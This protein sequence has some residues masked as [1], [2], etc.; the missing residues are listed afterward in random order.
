MNR[1]AWHAGTLLLV[2][3]AAVSA[4]PAP[5][6]DPVLIGSK[7][8]GKLTQR[9][10]FATGGTG[11]P[12]FKIVLTITDRNR[13]SFEAE[14][15]EVAEAQ[16]LSITY[17]VKGEIARDKDGKGYVIKFKSVAAKDIENTNPLLGIPYEAALTG[18]TMKGTWKI[19]RNKDGIEIEGDFEVELLKK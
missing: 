4:A 19:P 1:V 14:L 18:R 15:R 17:L 12:E 16:S 6:R 7:W 13:N 5:E 8:K 3:G 2:V 11:P 10:T 9:G